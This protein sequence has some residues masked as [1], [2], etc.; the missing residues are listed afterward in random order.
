MRNRPG[1]CEVTEVS[2]LICHSPVPADTTGQSITR[3]LGHRERVVGGDGG[4]QRHLLEV[5]GTWSHYGAVE[6]TVEG[7]R[8]RQREQCGQKLEGENCAYQRTCRMVWL[9]HTRISYSS[10]G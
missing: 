8:S 3:T 6:M 7:E 9:K 4:S 10:G 2:G 5:R 1:L